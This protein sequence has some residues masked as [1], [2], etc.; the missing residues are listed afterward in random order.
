M[1]IKIDGLAVSLH[2]E[3]GRFIQGA[4]R[5]DGVT[6]EDITQNLKTI[7]AIPLRLNEEVTLEARGEA[8][9]PKRSFVKL[10]EEKE[11]NGEDV[12]ANPRNAA[13]GSIR[14]LDP[15]IAAKRNLS[16]FV[17]GLANVEE[18]QFHHIVNRLIS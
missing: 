12:F 14:Q 11:Q 9:M 1:R 4:T 3:K 5:G 13:A 6:G 15:K 16:M 2:Y 10:N 17:Y 18:K 8:Y 7:K